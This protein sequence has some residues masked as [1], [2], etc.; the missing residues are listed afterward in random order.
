MRR[1]VLEQRAAPSRAFSLALPGISALVALLLGCVPLILI[2]ADPIEVYRLMV[3]SALGSTRDITD[4]LIDAVPIMLTGL[5]AVVTFRL[6]VWN[7]GAEGQLQMGAVTSAGMALLLSDGA[8]PILAVIAMVVAGILGGALYAALVALPAASWK[9]DEVV[10]TLMMNFIALAFI[11][12]LIFGS[13]SAWRDQFSVTFPRGKLIPDA[14]RLPALSGRLNLGFVIAIVAVLLIAWLLKHTVWGYEYGVVA[15]SRGT[16]AYSGIS[17]W[18][19]IVGS[20]L[21]SGACA[22]LGGA[23]LVGGTLGAMEPRAMTGLG[24]T[25]ILVAALGRMSPT[26]VIPASIVL[27]AIVSSGP[28]LQQIGVPAP[29][30][31]VLQGLILVVIAGGEFHLRYRVTMAG[32]TAPEPA[33]EKAE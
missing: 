14:S 2:G 7:I 30:T 28:D 8:N 6:N 18:R 33:Q 23:V 31:V 15:H 29:L 24:F 10:L 12:Y 20:F 11:N 1:L 19:M 17:Q 3:T 9:V 21:L 26:G 16:A 32:T 5:A 27:S 4:T 13:N 25:G 22:G